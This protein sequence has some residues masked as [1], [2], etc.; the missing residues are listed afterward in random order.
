MTDGENRLTL[1]AQPMSV[2]HEIE[3]VYITGE[4]GVAAQS[5]G[6][7][8]IPAAPLALG[9]YWGLLALVFMMAFLIW[10]LFD[11][12]KFL[13]KN[14]AGYVEYQKKVRHRLIPYVW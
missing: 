9:S 3:P 8:V 6:F 13:A 1:T 10:R 4:F 5:A 7:K 11:E 14:L 2:H 12:E